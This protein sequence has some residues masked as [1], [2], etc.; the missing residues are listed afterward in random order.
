MT[1][2]QSAIG[3]IAFCTGFCMLPDH[4][5]VQETDQ[6]AR[7]SP[8]SRSGQL[9]TDSS[10][11][12]C[13][14]FVLM[15]TTSAKTFNLST[16]IGLSLSTSHGLVDTGAQHGV[17]GKE[18]YVCVVSFLQTFGLKPRLLPTQRGGASGVGGESQFILTAE[19]PTAIQGVCGTVKLNVLSEPIP[20]LLPV[21]FSEHLG[22]ILNMPEKSIEWKFIERTQSYIR[23]PTGH[24]AVDCFEFPEG[25]WKNPHEHVKKPLGN[26]HQE[27]A[28]IIRSDFETEPEKSLLVSDSKVIGKQ[29]EA[30]S[31][32]LFHSPQS[33]RPKQHTLSFNW[34]LPDFDPLYEHSDVPIM[35]RTN[36]QSSPRTNSLRPVGSDVNEHAS[37][38]SSTERVTPFDH[39]FWGGDDLFVAAEADYTPVETPGSPGGSI[40]TIL[41][42]EELPHNAD[43]RRDD[44]PTR[45][46]GQRGLR[47]DLCES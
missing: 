28:G 7:D 41:A 44:L 2:G 35:P 34:T 27:N 18:Q 33:F 36:R 13:R 32:D 5:E 43:G 26:L 37:N 40:P 39:L 21:S 11:E 4:E 45:S 25:G 24:I 42:N 23:M 10:S 47:E 31:S 22:I 30:A 19:V 38:E 17:I 14:S 20:F 3:N 1:S 16:F 6:D 29:D 12:Y 9:G 15:N 46:V 8:A